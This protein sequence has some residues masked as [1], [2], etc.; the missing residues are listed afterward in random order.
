[1]RFSQ[2]IFTPLNPEKYAGRGTIRYRSSWEL[3]FMTFCDTHPN[4]VNWA[5]ES[6]SIPYHNPITGTTKSYVPDFLVF[7]Q[8]ANGRKKAELVEI[9]PSTETTM[10]AAGRNKK[11]QIQAVVNQAKW[12][13]AVKWC[14]N[15]NITFRVI[16][17]HDIFAG[18]R[19][20]KR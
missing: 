10:E 7:Y 14:R 1:M 6:I 11:A 2:G 12:A 16:T 18:T 15:Q 20:K 3:A 13:A 19:K 5:S 17:E 8:D 4:I 9:K